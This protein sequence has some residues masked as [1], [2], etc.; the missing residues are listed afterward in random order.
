LIKWKIIFDESFCK[1][2]VEG[3]C[4]FINEF[5][6]IQIISSVNLHGALYEDGQIFGHVSLFYSFNDGSLESISEINEWLIVIKFTSC[7][8]TSSPCKH[9]SNWVGWGFLSL[10]MESVMSGDC[11]M[12]SFGFNGT[13]WASQDW[14]HK[15]KRA[16]SLGNNIGLN[17]TIIIL[18]CPYESTFWFDSISNHIIN[19]SMLIPESKG[20]ELSFIIFLE[21]LFEDILESTIVFLHNC[22]LGTQIKWE[23]LFN[24]LFEASVS[25]IDNRFISVIHTHTNAWSFIVVNFKCLFFTT[26]SWGERHLQFSWPIENCICHSILITKGMSTNDNLLSPSWYIF[27]NVFN[28]DWSSENSSSKIVSESTIWWF[29]HLF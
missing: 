3:L 10:L 24:S 18:A 16:I 20:I 12:S 7:I 21:N 26:I 14:G 28:Q 13:A 6:S 4:N 11:T 2:F 23:L 27:W 25:E 22:I 17:I 1:I 19:K 5:E 9:W 8:E 29:P 15:T